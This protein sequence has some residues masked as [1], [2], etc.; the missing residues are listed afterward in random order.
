M[1]TYQEI[2]AGEMDSF[3]DSE[4]FVK[5][6]HDALQGFEEQYDLSCED[7]AGNGLKIRLFSTIDIRSN[8]G[9]GNGSDAMRL[10][11]MTSEGILRGA[12]LK[13]VHRVV[14]WRKNLMARYNEILNLIETGAISF[15]SS[16]DCPKC[17]E[18]VRTLLNGAYS[19]KTFM[20][21]SGYRKNDCRYTCDVRTG[22]DIALGQMEAAR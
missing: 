15:C 4:G 9:R 2:S 12:K 10:V 13:R 3:M 18:K 5:V 8:S 19:H 21:C 14:N 16:F 17:G 20:G 11:I 6:S 1:A 22:W 7:I